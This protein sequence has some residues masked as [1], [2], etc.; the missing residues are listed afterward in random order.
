[1]PRTRAGRIILLATVG[2][3]LSAIAYSAWALFLLAGTTEGAVPDVAR[4]GLPP[5]VETVS[6]AREC[7]SGGSW[8]TITVRPPAGQSAE[9]LAT[10]IGATPQLVLPGSIFDP[11]TVWVWAEPGAGDVVLR[12]D[13]WSQQ[14]IP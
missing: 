8:A 13:Y 9:D 4:I 11:R 3:V 10:E 12:A 14:H 1:M 2:T 5:A 7:A 6:E